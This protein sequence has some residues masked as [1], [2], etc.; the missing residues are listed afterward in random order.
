VLAALYCWRPRPRAR[1]TC[2]RE[3]S[4]EKGGKTNFEREKKRETALS[5]GKTG[6]GRG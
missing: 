1:A 6:G 2:E 4:N 3:A 5:S